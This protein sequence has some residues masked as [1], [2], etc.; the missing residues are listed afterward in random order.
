MQKI[1]A[2]IRLKLFNL[3][4]IKL[5]SNELPLNI[6]FT[7]INPI[8]YL[9]PL[10]FYEPRIKSAAKTAYLELEGGGDLWKNMPGK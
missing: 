8:S 9:L 2:A 1:E 10:I 3:V 4:Y 5:S 6:L 7:S